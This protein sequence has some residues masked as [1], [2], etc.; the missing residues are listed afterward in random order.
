MKKRVLSALLCLVMVVGLL[1][2]AVHADSEA[3]ECWFCDAVYYGDVDDDIYC[4]NCGTCGPNAENDCFFQ[5]HCWQCF[6]CYLEIN[7]WCTECTMCLDCQ[8]DQI[9]THCIECGDCYLSQEDELCGECHRCEGCS[10]GIC[11]DC[12]FCYDCAADDSDPM[13]CLI[14]DACFAS[15]EQAEH[16]NAK[17]CADCCSYCEQCG[18]W[19]TCTADDPEI[20]YCDECGLCMDCCMENR[21]AASGCLEYC[22]ESSEYEEHYCEDC[23]ECFCDKE[24]CGYCGLCT[25]CCAANSDCT[26][27]DPMCVEDG[28]YDD[29]FCPECGLCKCEG[30]DELCEFCGLCPECCKGEIASERDPECTDCGAFVCKEDPDFVEHMESAHGETITHTHRFSVLW[31]MDDHDHWHDCVACADGKNAAGSMTVAHSYNSQGICTTCGYKSG[32]T[33]YFTTQPRDVHTTVGDSDDYDHATGEHGK[34]HPYEIRSSFRAKAYG[35]GL[36]YQWYRVMADKDGTGTELVDK[37]DGEYT[38]ISGADTP[39]L[40]VCVDNEACCED[41]YF[42]CVATDK[43]GNTA[44]SRSARMIASHRYTYAGYADDL[45]NTS[46]KY[47]YVKRT[48]PGST[49]YYQQELPAS[50]GHRWYCC[51]EHSGD[52]PSRGGVKPHHFSETPYNAVQAAYTAKA[53]AAGEYTTFYQYRCTDC[54]FAKYVEKHEHRMVVA[55]PEEVGGEELFTKTS[56]PLICEVA[57]CDE[58]GSALHNWSFRTVQWPS[59]G[60]NG[61]VA[62]ECLDCGYWDEDFTQKVIN[63]ATGESSIRYWDRSNMLVE[64]KNGSV[65][66]TMIDPGESVILT[67]AKDGVHKFTGWTAKYEYQQEGD[68]IRRTVNVTLSFTKKADG[69]WTCTIPADFFAANGVLGGGKLTFTG[70]MDTAACAHSSVTDKVGYREAVCL[71]DG[72]TGDKVCNDCGKIVEKGE[73]FASGSGGKHTGV[74]TLQPDTAVEASCKTHGYE[75]DYKC[76]ACG[77]IV[78]GKSTPFEHGN[79][80]TTGYVAPTCMT[81]GYTGDTVCNDCGKEFGTG[82]VIPALKHDWDDGVKNTGRITT[83]TYTCKRCG[84]T[85]TRVDRTTHVSPGIKANINKIGFDMSGYAVG[86]KVGD[87]TVA[88]VSTLYEAS[89]VFLFKPT[90][91]PS[92]ANEPIDTSKAIQSSANIQ[93][94]E[95]YTMVI[96]VKLTNENSSFADTVTAKLG[97]DNG[98]FQEDTQVKIK[99]PVPGTPH[100]T[101]EVTVSASVAAFSL[102]PLSE[103]VTEAPEKYDVIVSGSVAENTGA[104]KYAKDETVTIDAGMKAGYTFNGWT[105]SDGVTLADAASTTTTFTMPAKSVSVAANWTNNHT[106]TYGKWKRMRISTGACAPAPTAPIRRSGRR[107]PMTM[108]PTPSAM[109]AAMCAR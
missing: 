37:A 75:G 40:T 15:A 96:V 52:R 51:G 90:D 94:G 29:H 76:S 62:R 71:T 83:I 91:M 99:V 32:E 49:G 79:K 63:T 81:D 53:A 20:E 105:A 89:T 3:H 31:S 97:R 21:N 70:T 23:G 86:N 10:G 100:A 72:Y 69:T 56:H 9:E 36:S 54:G 50:P 78:R 108:M 73:E 67:P 46:C 34:T 109:T 5:A 13:H 35:K 93:A 43:D 60:I 27:S 22:I 61:G 104:G 48:T 6:A 1:P 55:A 95:N 74:L 25:E 19:E 103:P 85:Y 17:H 84:E 7:D 101:Q 44:R 64:A 57:G 18:D 16:D 11:P 87:I 82:K 88:P 2:T 39:T 4:N 14:C 28:D 98:F 102:K 8:L 59:N 65:N 68:A 24:Q 12:G 106:H 66:R 41:I 80:V 42:Y 26:N 58:L 30:W 107:T 77:G 45:D 92:K 47:I 38:Y 33:V